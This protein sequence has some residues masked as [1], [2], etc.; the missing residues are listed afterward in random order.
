MNIKGIVFDKDGTLFD[1]QSSWG[2]TTFKFLRRLSNGNID[3]LAKLADEL[4]FDLNKK[5]FYLLIHVHHRQEEGEGHRDHPR[6]GDQGRQVRADFPRHQ[7]DVLAAA[8]RRL[9]RRA[10][11][12]DGPGN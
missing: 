8:R 7:G 12:G 11:G 9:L 10:D 5:V 6:R 4:Q 3:V 1:F 2:E